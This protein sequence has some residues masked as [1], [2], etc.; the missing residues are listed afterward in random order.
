[1][2]GLGPRIAVY[3]SLRDRVKTGVD[4][5]VWREQVRPDWNPLVQGRNADAIDTGV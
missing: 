4:L 1:M 5:A 2:S 3:A